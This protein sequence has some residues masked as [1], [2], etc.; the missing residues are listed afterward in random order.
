MKKQLEIIGL[1]R[2]ASLEPYAVPRQ[3]VVKPEPFQE[4]PAKKQITEGDWVT[5]VHRLGR[6]KRVK[7]AGVHRQRVRVIWPLANEV[8]EL[9]IKTGRVVT[10]KRLADWTLEPN[11]LAA[12]QEWTGK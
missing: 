10:R 11:A 4:W 1:D 2:V 6:V 12:A 3:R 9:S 5:I 7:F 8:L